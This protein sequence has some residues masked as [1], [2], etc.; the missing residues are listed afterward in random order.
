[1]FPNKNSRTKLSNDDD[2][3]FLSE[4]MM[5]SKIE[6]SAKFVRVEKGIQIY[7]NKEFLIFL[8]KLYSFL[9]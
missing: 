6:P 7:T 8:F 9:L 2:L 3:E 5:Q 4:Q 1:M